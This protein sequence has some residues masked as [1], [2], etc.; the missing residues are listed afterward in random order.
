MSDKTFTLIENDS[1]GN[2]TEKTISVKKGSSFSCGCKHNNVIV[3]VDLW[4]IE[5]ADCGERLDPIQYLVS[6]SQT[7]DQNEYRY[8][9]LWEEYQKVLGELNKKTKCEHCG[10]MTRIGGLE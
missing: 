8:K 7:Q 6:I 1:N 3:D 4:F 10:K 2:S 5:C 9:R